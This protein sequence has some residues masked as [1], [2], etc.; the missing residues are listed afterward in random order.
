MGPWISQKMKPRIYISN[1]LH[2]L[3]STFLPTTKFCNW[4]WFKVCAKLKRKVNHWICYSCWYLA[5]FIPQ[6]TGFYGP[7][8]S[9]VQNA[10]K[11]LVSQIYWGHI[12]YYSLI[13]LSTEKIH[14]TLYLN[15]TKQGQSQ[16]PTTLVKEK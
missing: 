10:H 7:L 12:R 6:L 8:N 14:I 15:N 11:V 4:N 13:Y 3:K 16:K 5:Y 2:T 9:I 1:V